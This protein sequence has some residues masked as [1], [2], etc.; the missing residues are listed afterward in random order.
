MRAALI[1]A[2]IAVPF[3]MARPALADEVR[4]SEVACDSKKIG[5][6]ELAQCLRS[7][8]DAADRDLL[9]QV[10]ACTKAIDGKQ[11]LLA[12]QKARWRHSLADA[13]SAWLTWRDSE[14]QD[15]A[16]FEAGIGV[17][18]AGDPR[19][20]CIIDQDAK[21]VADLKARYSAQ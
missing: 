18:G 20:A 21:R 19:L 15:V 14:C 4:P 9:A 5:A 10:E 13:E 3:L 2:V 16:P 1:F 6:R 12:T 11:G 17:K 7:A 8:S